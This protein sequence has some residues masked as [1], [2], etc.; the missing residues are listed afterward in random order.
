MDKR[1]YTPPE[2]IE[3]GLAK[4]II[5]SVFVDGSGDLFPAV[6]ELLASS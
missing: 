1:N 5:K 2:I 4:D 6:S 3:L